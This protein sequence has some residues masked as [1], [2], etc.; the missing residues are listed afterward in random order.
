MFQHQGEPW[1]KWNTALKEHLLANQ[2]NSGPAAGSWDPAD[3]WARIGGRIY[4]TAMC[5]L[6]LEVYY[7]Y[8]PLYS[9]IEPEAEQQTP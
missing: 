1:K 7:R 9:M 8:L 6:S 3:N 5:T 4:Q 2:R